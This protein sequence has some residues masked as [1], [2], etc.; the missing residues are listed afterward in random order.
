MDRREAES[1]G[2]THGQGSD[3]SS[4]VNGLAFALRVVR[5]PRAVASSGLPSP[6][7]D[8]HQPRLKLAG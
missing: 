4:R 2:H 8:R 7:S 5:V 1:R 6:T 3:Q